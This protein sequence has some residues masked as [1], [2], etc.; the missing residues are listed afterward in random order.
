MVHVRDSHRHRI[1]GQT[2]VHI[3]TKAGIAKGAG[4]RCIAGEVYERVAIWDFHLMSREGSVVQC[5]CIG[6]L[7]RR[8]QPNDASCTHH[9]LE[10]HA[11]FMTRAKNQHIARFLREFRTQRTDRSTNVH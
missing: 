5:E 6:G 11:T 2:V 7:A 4:V 10:C 3:G 8:E 1:D 9:V